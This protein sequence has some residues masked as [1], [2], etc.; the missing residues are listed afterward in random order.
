MD[1]VGI[2]KNKIAVE[3]ESPEGFPGRD[4]PCGAFKNDKA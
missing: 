1:S 4:R 2:R 3:R